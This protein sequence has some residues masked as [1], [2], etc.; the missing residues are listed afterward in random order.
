M[1]NYLKLILVYIKK[2]CIRDMEYRVNMV[3]NVMTDL[4][5]NLLK[6]ALIEII[7]VNVESIV[8]FSKYQIMYIFGIS[9]IVMSIYMTFVFFNH[10][11]MPCK[12]Q[13]GDLDLLLTKPVSPIF[14][15]SFRTFNTAGIGS[16]IFGAY[17]LYISAKNLHLVWG[18]K[19]IV[20][21][22]LLIL[23]GFTAYYSLSLFI[24]TFAFYTIKTNGFINIIVDIGEIMK[25]P[26]QLFPKIVQIILSFVVPV[27]MV[28]TYPAEIMLHQI[29]MKYTALCILISCIMLAVA[30]GFFQH[31]IKKYSSASC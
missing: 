7:F 2:S 19:E 31:A 30:R 9:F 1:N 29:P 17:V 15:L 26:F 21:L 20:I 4:I 11:M 12:I 24:Y 13:S 22:L 10:I 28:A 27:F 6:I 23:S 8:G 14:E 5:F 25:Y 18:G 3:T 16:G